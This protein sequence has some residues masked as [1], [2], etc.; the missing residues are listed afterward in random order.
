MDIN[1]EARSYKCLSTNFF[2]E[3]L[4]SI[5]PL[6]EIDMLKIM[7]WRNEQIYHLRQVDP[8][9]TND[10]DRY[11]STVIKP[12]FLSKYPK[13]ILFTFLKENIAI[14]YGG[15]VH[16]D[17]VNKNAEISF[18]MMTE[19]EKEYFVTNWSFFL[20][21][22]E[23]VAFEQLNFNKIFTY[24]YDIRPKLFKVLEDLNYTK[25]AI[26]KNHVLINGEFVDVLI[27][28]KFKH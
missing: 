23:K 14:G 17:W 28:S 15:L 22:I 5:V 26:L 27:H 1:M 13:Q 18:I 24:A 20:S 19:L 11:Y 12:S 25:E 9:T 16:I 10:Q 3:N 6:R 2:S 8:L 7:Q 21:L 4:Y